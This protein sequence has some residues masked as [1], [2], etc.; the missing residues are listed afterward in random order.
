MIKILI[1]LSMSLF[2]AGR[3]DAACYQS[4]DNGGSGRPTYTYFSPQSSITIDNSNNAVNTV[5][6]QQQQSPSSVS[7]ISCDE[8]TVEIAWLSSQGSDSGQVFKNNYHIYTTPVEGVGFTAA[9]DEMGAS[10]ASIGTF[11]MMN[12][13]SNSNPSYSLVTRGTLWSMALIVTGP[14]TGG[15]IP[16]GIYASYSVGGVVLEYSQLETSVTINTGGCSVVGDTNISVNL[17]TVGTGKLPAVGSV[18]NNTPFNIN[19]SCNLGTKVSLNVSGTADTAYPGTLANNGDAEGVGVQVLMDNGSP[20][21]LNQQFVAINSA[22][23]SDAI[24]MSG[25]II[26]TGNMTAGSIS[27]SATYTLNYQ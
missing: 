7:N 22:A 1:F 5:L 11:P 9:Y 21:T 13:A 23:S 8:K 24:T 14:V 19:L 2:F 20:I 15:V 16:A 12:T 25:Q 17:G 10:F 6:W 3:S 27:S 4:T 26:R 18:I